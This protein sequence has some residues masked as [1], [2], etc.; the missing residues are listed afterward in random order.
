VPRLLPILLLVLAA[1]PASAQEPTCRAELS[2]MGGIPILLSASGLPCERFD[3]VVRGFAGEIVALERMMSAHTAEGVVATINRG[4]VEG[5]PCPPELAEVLRTAAEVS[6]ATEG[7]FDVTVRPLLQVWKAAAREGR[8]A[9][10]EEI[11]EALQRVSYE[12]VKVDGDRVRIDRPGVS[13]DL[14]GIAK[15]YFGDVAIRRLRD[16]GATRCIADIGADLVTWRAPDTR[17]FEVGI[18]NPWGEGLMGALTV[19]NG[20]VVT[21]GDYERFFTVGDRR[22]CHIVDPRTGAPVEGMESVTVLAP[23]GTEADALATGIFVLGFDAGSALVESRPDLEAVIVAAAEDGSDE[24]RVFV[25][26]GLVDRFRW[27]E[28]ANP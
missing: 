7:G 1:T 6:V 16:A 8:L 10:D 18:R 20:S 12:V 2:A 9:T 22:I 27:A 3:A 25:S 15:G 13:I 4:G 24:R 19:A 21:S 28:G 5:G 26:S 17:E 14:G 11:A 23:T